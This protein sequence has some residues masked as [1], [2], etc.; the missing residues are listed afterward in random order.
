M[1]IQVQQLGTVTW[2]TSAEKNNFS[3]RVSFGDF[4]GDRIHDIAVN[5]MDQNADT[6]DIQILLGSNN[7]L[8][9]LGT[10]ILGDTVPT[11]QVDAM[12]NWTEDINKDGINDIALGANGGDPDTKAAV[13]GAPQIVYLSK[14]YGGFDTFQSTQ[15]VYA[16]H[17]TVNDING[18]GYLD[19]FS[20]TCV[21]G[22]SI[23][24]FLD[25]I[26]NTINFTAEGVP[27]KA[28]KS[29][30]VG[31]WDLIK[32]E[33]GKNNDVLNTYSTYHLHNS[34][35][36]DINRDG[37]KDLLIF[38]VAK[39]ARAFLNTSSN[40]TSFSNSDY[41]DIDTSLSFLPYN[42]D[43]IVIDW[44]PETKQHTLT[45][46]K[47]GFNPYGSVV[48]DVN[49]DGWT[50]VVVNGSYSDIEY[51]ID[52]NGI[53]TWREGSDNF[54]DGTL[55]EVF[56][57]DGTTLINETEQR[58]T[59]YGSWENTGYH[60]GFID[61]MKLVDINGDGY[62]DFM[63]NHSSDQNVNER[64]SWDTAPGV[65][66]T[67][68]MLN[69][70]NG[71]FSPTQIAG[72]DYGAFTAVPIMGKVGYMHVKAATPQQSWTPANSEETTATFFVTN[73]PW[74]IGDDG[75]NFL[76][77][78]PAW[79]QI[80]GGEGIDTFYANGRKD[81]FTLT[82]NDD[83]SFTIADKS[84]LGGTD[85]LVNIETVRFD[86]IKLAFDMSTSDQ[87]QLVYRIYQAAFARMPDEG[88]FRYWESFSDTL[89][90]LQYAKEFRTSEEFALKYGADVTNDKYTETLYRNV[91][92][93]E[94]DAGGLS[95]WQGVLNSGGLDRD[96]LLIEF[97]ACAENVTLTAPHI[98]NGYWLV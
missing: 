31:S 94:P 93:R 22:P 17:L 50:D 13:S 86:D 4:N 51:F 27:E 45:Q 74:T 63:S 21:V 55:Y 52:F 9:T 83:G 71:N 56:I 85:T 68:F 20:T 54:N 43:T 39:E 89:T 95:Y 58:I 53:Q 30:T 84:C 79:D 75:N 82:R 60:D 76:Y 35:F 88:G 6:S 7:G 38:F 61:N 26:N 46:Y 16:H 32:T 18:D 19:I 47:T 64:P 65:G 40:S 96:Q 42:G 49:N 48:F 78:T 24:G 72:L 33:N 62:L 57:S 80:D 36:I 11:Y 37:L 25:P 90:P 67:A 77:S 92:Q 59:Q 3:V 41:I 98:D 70:G 29:D 8:F 44:Y 10:Q 1:D 81:G 12:S 69:D 97:A 73:V 91:L 28:V 2:Q 15:E 23:F 87:S 66:H 5:I 14:K 34:E